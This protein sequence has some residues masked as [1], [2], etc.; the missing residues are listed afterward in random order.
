MTQRILT[1]LVLLGG[2]A[3]APALAGPDLVRRVELL[4][5]GSYQL[6]L[7]R[8]KAGAVTV[9]GPDPALAPAVLDAPGSA[10][11]FR[12]SPEHPDSTSTWRLAFADGCDLDLELSGQQGKV[13]VPFRVSTRP[14]EP[15]IRA[16]L[17]Y[18][19]FDQASSYNGRSYYR[20]GPVTIAGA[21]GEEDVLIAVSKE[22]PH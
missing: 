6:K 1:A 15:R 11:T 21:T 9:T 12:K 13:K 16:A 18:G 2:M 20:K 14:D 10:V 22:P 3:G 7:I 8:K 19:A 4:Y 5:P 17:V